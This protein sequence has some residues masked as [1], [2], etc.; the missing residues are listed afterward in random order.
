[1][2]QTWG[3]EKKF[4]RVT[5]LGEENVGGQ[6]ICGIYCNEAKFELMAAGTYRH[7]G[8]TDS[9]LCGFQLVGLENCRKYGPLK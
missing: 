3:K 7:R 8:L 9:L 5:C 6:N 2:H 1:M 4:G